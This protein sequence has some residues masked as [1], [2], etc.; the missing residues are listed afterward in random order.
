VTTPILAAMFAAFAWGFGAAFSLVIGGAVSLIR[1]INRKALGLTMAFG[2]GVLLSAVAYD[3]V[4]EGFNVS[5][6]PIAV[7]LGLAGGALTF[8]F[9]DLAIDRLGGANRKRAQGMD[10]ADSPLAIVLGIILDGIPESIVIG[11][12]LLGGATIDLAVV[13]AV[14]LSNIPESVSA[15]VGLKQSG[16]A[17]SRILG[18]WLLVSLVSGAAAW[19]GFAAFGALEPR[20]IALV[21]AFAAGAILTMLTDTM[22]PEGFQLGGRQ[23]GLAVTLGFGLAFGLTILP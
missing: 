13:I 9:G 16:W 1:P 19:F 12:T 5:A 23:A 15:T 11:L 22:I 10:Q 21:D 3:L 6:D 14:F 2:S 20:A 4:Q 18:L 8:Y 7:A 17:S